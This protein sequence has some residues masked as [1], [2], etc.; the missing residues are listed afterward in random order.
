MTDNPVQVIVAAFNTPDGAG[1]VMSDLKQ[2]KKAG[3]ISIQDAAVVVKD[4]NGKVK[5]TDAK[6][7][8]AKGLI[9]GGILGGLVGL[10]AAPSVAAVAAG[11]GAIGAL[12]GKLKNAPLKAEM[13]EIGSALP[14]NTSAIVA[15]IEHNQEAQL[16]AL[17]TALADEAERVVRDS[18]KADIAEQLSAG[19]NVLYTAGGGS[20]ASGVGRVAQTPEGTQVS[21]IIASE[22]GVFVEDAQ[23]TNEPLET[24]K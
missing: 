17:E 24:A 10:L 13:K 1:K 18:L 16:E 6:H 3:L 22:D 21:G 5:I 9:T 7:R 11:G 23:I 12:I 14:P 20:M 19:G 8:T 15:A 4:T 2:G